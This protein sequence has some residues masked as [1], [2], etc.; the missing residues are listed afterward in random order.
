MDLDDQMDRLNRR[1][2]KIEKARA[3]IVHT[4]G[5][6]FKKGYSRTI[7]GQTDCPCCRGAGTLRFRRSGI[8]GHIKARCLTP[9]CISWME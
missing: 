2:D 5:G 7:R 1:L 3:V 9:D 4:C 8:N 6:A